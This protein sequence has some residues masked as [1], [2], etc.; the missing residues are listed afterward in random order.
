M[1]NSWRKNNEDQGTELSKANSLIEATELINHYTE[2][3]WTQH[4]RAINYIYKKGATL[5]MF[6]ETEN[7]FDNAVQS[8]SIIY[9]KIAVYKIL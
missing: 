3:E 7:F 4:N 9:F 8:R 5:K 1:L 2:M 6:K